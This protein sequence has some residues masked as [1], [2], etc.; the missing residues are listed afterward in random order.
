M[1]REKPPLLAYLLAEGH[2]TGSDGEVLFLLPYRVHFTPGHKTGDFC[3]S[4]GDGR[5]GNGTFMTA[6]TALEPEW[7]GDLE[8]VGALWLLPL[9]QRMAGGEAVPAS[10]ILGAYKKQHGKKPRLEE[11]QV[12]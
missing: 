1:P 2:P 8:S 4:A 6:A 12:L 5:N 10:E 3:L 7:R 11:W 9:L